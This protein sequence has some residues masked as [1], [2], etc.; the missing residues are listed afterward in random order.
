MVRRVGIIGLG[1]IGA[2]LGLALKQAGLN[3]VELVGCSRSPGN[4]AKALEMGAVDRLVNSPVQAV[5]RAELV[6][7]ATPI[8][9]M[10]GILEEIGKHLS[11]GCIV[12]DTASTKARVMEWAEDYL[13][14]TVSFVGGHPM[15][16]KEFSGAWAAEATLFEN[17]TYC[18]IPGRKASAE[19]VQQMTG[20]VEGMGARPLFINADEHDNFVAGIS[21]LPFLVSTALV[22]TTAKNSSWDKMSELAAIG[23]RDTTRL[24]SSNPEMFRDICFSNRD[25]I[26]GWIDEFVEELSQIRQ[27]IAGNNEALE[28]A[29][30]DARQMRQQWLDR[31]G[32]RKSP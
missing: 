12:T 15:A 6:I 30:I 1:L 18:L 5:D 14:R 32:N 31:K 3:K 27:L 16:G 19:A 24:A 25:N 28:K 8:M 17:C 22:S 21:H 23:Y 29:L 2:S 11:Q 7:L 26:V 10:K 13:P 9:A 20:F 4:S